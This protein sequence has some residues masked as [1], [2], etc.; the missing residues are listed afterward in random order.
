MVD[1][2]TRRDV[3]PLSRFNGDVEIVKTAITTKL[4]RDAPERHGKWERLLGGLCNLHGIA[5]KVL[6][7]KQGRQY[8]EFNGKI[9]LN[10]YSIISLLHEFGHAIGL[11]HQG[12]INCWNYS[13][14]V[15]F[16]ANPKAKERLVKNE[17][18]IW[19]KKPQG[20]SK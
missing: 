12:T 13:E 9:I 11:K 15:Y 3:N 18:R 20:D 8:S 1:L 10:K 5:P 2:P 19:V 6:V 14:Y 7:I 16:T 4:Y 17:K